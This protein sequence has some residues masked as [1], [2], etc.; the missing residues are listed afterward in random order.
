[1]QRQ[2]TLGVVLEN[3]ED[4]H[5]IAAIL[6]TCD[7]AGVQDIY[8][9]DSEPKLKNTLG[10]KSSRSATK[11]MTV[12]H[13][14]HVKDCIQVLKQRFDLILT[15]HLSSDAISIYETDLTRSV[16][17]VFG[18]EKEG[19]SKEIMK[20]SDGNIVI[21]QYGM[22]QSLNISVACAVTIFE[23]LRQRTAK[24]MY[25][26]AS[27]PTEVLEALHSKWSSKRKSIGK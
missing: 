15:T 14:N 2:Y 16:A 9:I 1:M 25:D 3:V 23:A 18:N 6:R 10:W 12:H 22:L 13:F 11:W 20:Y 7:A 21:P 26:S 19:L 4:P 8:V 17:L 24:G 5:N 27:I